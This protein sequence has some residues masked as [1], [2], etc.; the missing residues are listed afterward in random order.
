MDDAAVAIEVRGLS[1]V[2]GRRH[3]L[4]DVTF[5]VRAGECLAITGANG[6]GKTTL[7]GCLASVLR[8]TAGEVRWFGRPAAGNPQARRLIGMA[9]HE[10]RLY[11]YLTLRENLLFAAR[12][13]DV[14]SPRQRADGL[15]GELGLGPHAGRTPGEISRG[16]RQRLAL[17]RALVHDPPLLLLDEPFA[18]L[19]E[20]GTTWLSFL[21]GDL[22]ARRRTI[23]F[24]EHDA[25]KVRHLADRVLEIRAGR[26]C[27]R[28]VPAQAGPV[29]SSPWKRAA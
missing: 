24:S 13:Y 18:G 15:L 26:V 17:A 2:F 9:A 21:L 4:R 22:R 1:K 23:C 8:P 12:M 16:M 10:G 25:A 27:E 7:L 29:A 6:A 5:D 3:V 28:D 11:P 14:P 19:D 20:E